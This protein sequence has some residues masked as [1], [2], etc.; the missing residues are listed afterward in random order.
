MET[1]EPELY[2]RGLPHLRAEG[3]LYFVTWRLKAGQP[4]L[5]A[6][7]RDDVLAAL[8]WFDGVRYQL[9][10]AVVMNDHVHVIVKPAKAVP[11]QKILHSWKSFTAHK[12]QNRQ[13]RVWQ[14]EYFDRI[15][16]D[17]AEYREKRDY[18]L[19]NPQKRWPNLVDY[20]WV[21]AIG[22]DLPAAR[23]TPA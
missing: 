7:E 5:S 23:A 12:L 22:M 3:A 2:R 21:W 8:R 18:I 17:D 14:V 19:K 10:S 1:S 11:L 15:I 16:R 9:H 4:D 20:G 6:T 13:G